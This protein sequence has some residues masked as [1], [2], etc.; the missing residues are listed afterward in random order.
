MPA[1]AAATTPIRVLL[2]DSATLVLAGLR[3]V[4][5][6]SPDMEIVGEA[7]DGPQAL[8][9]ALRLSPDVVVLDVALPGLTGL[10]VLDELSARCPNVRALVLSQRRSEDAVR[11]AFEHGAA[12]Y[13]LKDENVDELPAVVRAVHSGRFHLS[14]GASRVVVRDYVERG[15]ATR[16]KPLTGREREILGLVATGKT[17]RDIGAQLGIALRTV[18]THRAH[19]MRKLDVHT[20]AGLVHAA[21]RLGMFGHE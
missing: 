5:S 7:H 4:L 10:E 17:S 15:G 2:A 9:M 19:I 13:F 16:R 11:A 21:M 3:F 12:G 8:Q 20:E 6:R 18:H 14:S 1:R